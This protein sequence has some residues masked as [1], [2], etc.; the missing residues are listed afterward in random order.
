MEKITGNISPI[1]QIDGS[2]SLTT[3]IIS[4]TITYGNGG[5]EY[6]IPYDGVYEVTPTQETQTLL[7]QGKTLERDVVV[8]P[9]PSNYGRIS[10]NGSVLTVS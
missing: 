4:G 7:T 6:I 8:N 2:I 1:N 3:D 5:S 10:Y 9:I